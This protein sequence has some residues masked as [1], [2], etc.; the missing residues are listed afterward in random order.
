ME[1]STSAVPSATTAIMPDI[2]LHDA[3]ARDLPHGLFGAS[4]PRESGETAAGLAM[5]ASFCPYCEF[6]G[7]ASSANDTAALF[8][9]PGALPYHR[10]IGPPRTQW[11]QDSGAFTYGGPGAEGYDKR[12][13]DLDYLSLAFVKAGGGLVLTST[14]CVADTLPD[15]SGEC[16][17]GHTAGEAVQDICGVYGGVYEYGALPGIRVMQYGMSVGNAARMEEFESV[18]HIAEEFGE[19][20]RD[21]AGH[22][23]ARGLN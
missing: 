4:G 13:A 12:P 15:I 9:P 10:E 3:A 8:P 20:G 22:D 18:H 7:A 21:D 11:P 16:E 2:T 6:A 1:L 5:R 14:A 17:R 23:D 19:T